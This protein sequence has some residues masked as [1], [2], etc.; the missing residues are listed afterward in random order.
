M[1]RALG[2]PGLMLMSEKGAHV[3]SNVQGG[4]FISEMTGFPSE[5]VFLL[6][7]IQIRSDPGTQN[8]PIQPWLPKK[9]SVF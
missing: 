9:K 6:V 5:I 4:S 3:M 7:K 1:G 2:E 8:V